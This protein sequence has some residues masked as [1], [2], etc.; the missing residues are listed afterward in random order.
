MC[1]RWRRR[2]C[3]TAW[4]SAS[5]AAPRAS[6]WPG[7]RAD[8]GAAPLSLTA[9]ARRRGFA[10]AAGA[11]CAAR[12]GRA[13]RRR[14]AA[15]AGRRR[16]GRRRPSRKACTAAAA[17]ARARPSGNSANTSPATPQPHR[18]ARERQVAAALC[19]RDRM[20][21]GAERLAVARRLGVDGLQLGR[22]RR[23]RRVADQARPRRTAPGRA[24]EPAGA[25]RRAR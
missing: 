4:R 17:S 8:V 23:R 22:L 7:H 3:G 14:A 2:C 25:R 24:G 16:A 19:P 11:G 1:W 18:L 20:G 10:R 9:T 21:S 5:P 13:G 6:R 15:A 12:P